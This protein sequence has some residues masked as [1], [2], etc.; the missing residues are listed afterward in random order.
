MGKL[1]VPDGRAA[2]NASIDKPDA[3]KVRLAT[4]GFGVSA[5][6]QTPVG[7]MLAW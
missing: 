1:A 7:A 2:D 5:T 3:I 4:A 6:A